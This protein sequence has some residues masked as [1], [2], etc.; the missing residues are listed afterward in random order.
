[1]ATTLYLAF[2]DIPVNSAKIATTHAYEDFRPYW[3]LFRGERYHHGKLAAATGASRSLT[4]T[5]PTGSAQ[6]VNYYI[7]ARADLLITQGITTFTLERSS[8]GSSWTTADSVTLATNLLIGPRSQD[9]IRTFT[10]TSAYQ[11]WRAT[12]GGSSAANRYSKLYFG[13]LFDIG[14]YPDDFRFNLVRPKNQEFTADSGAVHKIQTGLSKYD[15]EIT[16]D[17][18]SD[19]KCQELINLLRPNYQGFFLYAPEQIQILDNNYLMHVKAVSFRKDDQEGF[20]DWNRLTVE[21]QEL[22]G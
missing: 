17:G 16:W 14:T 6:S 1:M 20:P 2:P 13:T 4:F 11:Y 10:A 12:L 19:A 3:N 7:I 9:I 18:V 15:I 22:I 8:D 5:L 21:F